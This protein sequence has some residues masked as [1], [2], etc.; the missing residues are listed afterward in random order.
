MRTALVVFALC[1]FIFAQEQ[2]APDFT[3]KNL[4]GESVSLPSLAGKTVVIDFWAMWCK[5]CKEA[6]QELNKIQ[7]EFA[8]KGV[9]VMGINLEKANPEKVKAFAQKA[10]IA[11]TILLDPDGTTAKLYN[12]KGVPSLAIVNARGNLVK[13]FRGL[14]KDTEKEIRQTLGNLTGGK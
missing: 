6:F 4:S 5:S 12:V 8:D 1:C 9:V 14:N 7:L 11:Y 13:T 10:G 3:L 2:K